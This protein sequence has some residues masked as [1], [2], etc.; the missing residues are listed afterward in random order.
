MTGGADPFRR[1]ASARR[2]T[3]IVPTK[4]SPGV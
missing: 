2:S 4:P 3:V 1:V